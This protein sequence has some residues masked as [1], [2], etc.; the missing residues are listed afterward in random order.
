MM[1][2]KYVDRVSLVVPEDKLDQWVPVSNNF[3]N[4]KEDISVVDLVS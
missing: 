1:K 3:L 2:N 4:G